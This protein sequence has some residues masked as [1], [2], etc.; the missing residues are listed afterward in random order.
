MAVFAGLQCKDHSI[1][2][3]TDRSVAVG[4]VINGIAEMMLHRRTSRDDMRGVDEKLD[5]TSIIRSITY[6]KL[7]KKL[8]APDFLDFS[9]FSRFPPFALFGESRNFWEIPYS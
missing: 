9:S 6:I 4:H 3:W 2:L 5:D 1:S 7:D 8:S